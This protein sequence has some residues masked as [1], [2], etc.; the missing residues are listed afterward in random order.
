MQLSHLKQTKESTFQTTPNWT[1]ALTAT[2]WWKS[3]IYNRH[4]R[5]V[6]KFT[7]K[8]SVDSYEIPRTRRFGTQ[9]IVG[10]WALGANFFFPLKC[11]VM[12]AWDSTVDGWTLSLTH[13]GQSHTE[14]HHHWIRQ[15]SQ[16]NCHLLP[17]LPQIA[18]TILAISL[19][20]LTYTPAEVL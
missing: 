6:K 15:P 7:E 14:N 3:Q 11:T 12:T 16:E 9:K 4:K 8:W 5:G 17:P 10:S 2:G 1:V 19:C 18:G 20:V 13:H